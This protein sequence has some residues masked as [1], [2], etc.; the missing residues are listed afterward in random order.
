MV[1]LHFQMRHV[2]VVVQGISDSTVDFAILLCR[3]EKVR[4]ISST[5]VLASKGNA[6]N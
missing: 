5:L 2:A 3:K 6:L 1:G 4:I